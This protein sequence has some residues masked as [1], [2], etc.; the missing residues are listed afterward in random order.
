MHSE[1]QL[2]ANKSFAE[3]AHRA[4]AYPDLGYT[5]VTSFE[6]AILPNKCAWLGSND[7]WWMVYSSALLL[8]IGLVRTLTLV[9]LS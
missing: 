5:V 4:S 1:L 2:L 8:P 3:P 6:N 9:T 7:G